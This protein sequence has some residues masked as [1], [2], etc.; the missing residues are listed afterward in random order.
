[1]TARA[2]LARLIPALRSGPGRDHPESAGGR[3]D[4]GAED[5]LAEM[6][7]EFAPTRLAG[8]LA[9]WPARL[10]DWLGT[11]EWSVSLVLPWPERYCE[12]ACVALACAEVM[13]VTLL[14]VLVVPVPLPHA[15]RLAVAAVVPLAVW[16]IA[17]I[18]ACPRPSAEPGRAGE[19]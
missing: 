14:M 15:D 18:Q 12:L 1:V 16:K 9:S 4:E 8:L 6:E 19:R 2:A 11:P 13:A 17:G 5:A 3:L 7:L 10:M